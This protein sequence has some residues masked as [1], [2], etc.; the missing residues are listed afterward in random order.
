M[1]KRDGHWSRSQNL[2]WVKDKL[3]MRR[4]VW[5]SCICV[6]L[7]WILSQ[8]NKI[9]FKANDICKITGNLLFLYLIFYNFKNS[10]LSIIMYIVYTFL[11]YI[12]DRYIWDILQN[13]RDGEVGGGKNEIRLTRS[14]WLFRLCDR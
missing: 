5:K 1:S 13:N 11:K 10:F 14:W 2:N 4:A 7:A 9:F 12:M 6:N 8:T 3:Y